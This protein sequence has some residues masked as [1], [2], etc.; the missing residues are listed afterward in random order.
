MLPKAIPWQ[1]TENA[2]KWFQFEQFNNSNFQPLERQLLTVSKRWV[3][4]YSFLVFHLHLF[5]KDSPTNIK[6][7]YWLQ[8]SQ[9]T[10][11][12]CT[13]STRE[14]SSK[15]LS[16]D[17]WWNYFQL[18]M[19]KCLNLQFKVENTKGICHSLALWLESNLFTIQVYTYTLSLHINTHGNKINLVH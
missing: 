12:K 17:C 19:R 2:V 10:F 11:L 13:L 16:F 4:E 18:K 14:L 7:Y 15:T 8:H 3:S 1:S 6:H 5:N 9:V